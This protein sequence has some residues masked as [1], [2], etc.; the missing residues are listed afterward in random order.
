MG[1]LLQLGDEVRLKDKRYQKLKLHVVGVMG[2][3]ISV[4]R[5]DQH[6]KE[7]RRYEDASDLVKVDG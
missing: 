5:I 1:N 3:R 2:D 4:E 6:K 7:W